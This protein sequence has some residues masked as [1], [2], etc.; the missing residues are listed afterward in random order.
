MAFEGISEKLNDI[1]RRL[2]G[3]GK[4]SEADVKAVMREIKL[5]LLAADVIFKV[6]KAFF[7]NVTE[8]AVV[9]DVLK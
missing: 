8:R 1:F 9:E 2:K 5:D 6:V 3:R 7:A 4:L